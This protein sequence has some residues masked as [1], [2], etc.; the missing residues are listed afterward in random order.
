MTDPHHRNN[1]PPPEAGRGEDPRPMT[2]PPVI[3]DVPAEPAATAD[4]PAKR[5]ATAAGPAERPVTTEVPADQPTPPHPPAEPPVAADAPAEPPPAADVPAE[6]SAATDVPAEPPAEAD[7][8][9]EAAAEADPSAKPLSPALDKTFKIG[10]VLKGLDGV[11][12]VIG[13]LLLLF[14]SP[15]AIERIVRALTAHELSEDPHD[16]I[17]RYLLHTTAHL[18]HGTTL[19]GAI[20]LLSHGIAKIVLVALVLRDKLWAYPWLIGLLL[21][22]IAYQLYQI[23]AVHFSAGLA[24]LTVFDA[25]LVWLTWREYRAKRARARPV[26]A[27]VA[28]PFPG[29]HRAARA[30]ADR[31][32]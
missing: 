23:T 10:L 9:A 4:A 16:V 5:P 24:A 6:R 29:D 11:L 15:Q 18:H 12:E 3:A 30:Q 31:G 14:L 8:P 22:F 21:A 32:A 17:A 2:R 25:L 13:G 1:Q 19:F 20:Y 28:A 27:P 7:A 26:Q